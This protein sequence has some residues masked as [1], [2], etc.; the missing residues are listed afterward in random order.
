M[1]SSDSNLP[2]IELGV[3]ILNCSDNCQKFTPSSATVAFRAAECMAVV[4][5][6]SIFT[7]MDLIENCPYTDFTGIRI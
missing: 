1:V 6:D 5:Y 2:S 3:K 7:I 4:G